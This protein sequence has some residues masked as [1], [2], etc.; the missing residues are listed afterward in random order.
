MMPSELLKEECE[1]NLNQD[2]KPFLCFC[3]SNSA[4]HHLTSRHY[5]CSTQN[6]TLAVWCCW[7][8]LL[9][10]L[11]VFWAIFA[12]LGRYPFSVLERQQGMHRE[13]GSVSIWSPVNVKKPLLNRESPFVCPSSP[14]SEGSTRAMSFLTPF[15]QCKFRCRSRH[16]HEIWDREIPEWKF[17]LS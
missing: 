14:A 4:S 13:Q 9:L 10:F 17:C 7:L 11:K 1:H 6:K 2:A 3:T 16:L 12:G 15:H 8:F 5:N